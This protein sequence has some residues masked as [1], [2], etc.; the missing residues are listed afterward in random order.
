ME[1]IFCAAIMVLSACM[2]Y[3]G[4]RSTEAEH[5]INRMYDND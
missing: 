1:A 2:F 3:A 4:Y 5:D